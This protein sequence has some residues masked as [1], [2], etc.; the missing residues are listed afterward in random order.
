MPEEATE[1]TKLESPGT[2][3]APV[4]P[5]TPVEEPEPEG[6]DE[7]DAG[8]EE[9]QEAAAAEGL[10]LAEARGWQGFRLDDIGGANVGKIEGVYADEATK[11]PEWLLARMGRFGHHCLVPARDAVAAAGHVWVPYARADIRKAPRIEAGKPIDRDSELA[12]LDHYGVGAREAG[13]GG[14]ISGSDPDAI[15]ARPVD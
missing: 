13:R 15:T 12:L 3:E 11:R 14:D 6:D 4:A 8:E 1:E 9:D 10:T 5:E 7:G 2:P